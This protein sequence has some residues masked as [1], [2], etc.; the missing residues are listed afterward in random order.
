MSSKTIRA[1]RLPS[2]TEEYDRQHMDN[3]IRVLNLYFT[4]LDNPGPLAAATQRTGSSII[5]A[6]S[7]V[8][9]TVGSSA[10]AIS[11]P[12]QADLAS[13]RTG[14]VYYDTTAGNVLKIKT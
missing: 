1:P 14:D 7:F 3:L 12:T 5:A 13:L 11:L 8:Q 6:L 10:P 4:Q 2:A 9:P